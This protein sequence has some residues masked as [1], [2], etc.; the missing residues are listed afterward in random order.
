MVSMAMQGII[1]QDLVYHLWLLLW[2]SPSSKTGCTLSTRMATRIR[3]RPANWLRMDITKRWNRAQAQHGQLWE[4]WTFSALRLLIST[5]LIS[6]MAKIW[7]DSCPVCSF[8]QLCI[9]YANERLQ[10]HFI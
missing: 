5:G 6:L 8:E 2:Q 10:Q 7:L 3:I 4:Y 9:N 1:A